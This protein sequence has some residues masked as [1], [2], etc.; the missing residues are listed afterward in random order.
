MGGSESIHHILS[1]STNPEVGVLDNFKILNSSP[2]LL[3]SQT[4]DIFIFPFRG[5]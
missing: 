1:I 5:L 4:H 3:L 2:C